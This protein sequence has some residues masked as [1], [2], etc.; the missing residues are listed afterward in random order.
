MG[1]VVEYLV[2]TAIEKS[3]RFGTLIQGKAHCRRKFFAE[4]YWQFRRLYIGTFGDMGTEINF[5]VQNK[6]LWRSN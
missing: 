2:G 5:S 4:K 6:T 3:S 1:I